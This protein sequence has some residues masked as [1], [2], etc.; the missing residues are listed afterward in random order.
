[1]RVRVSPWTPYTGKSQRK[2]LMFY[3]FGTIYDEQL[4]YFVDLEGANIF[5]FDNETDLHYALELARQTNAN[6]EAYKLLEE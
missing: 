3:V 6:F 4:T 5:K 1:M 2:K